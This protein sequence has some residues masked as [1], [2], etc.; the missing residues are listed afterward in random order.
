MISVLFVDDDPA[1]L[2]AGKQF[3]EQQGEF[4]VDTVESAMPALDGLSLKPYDAIISEYGM[5]VID[6]IEFLKKVRSQ[7]ITTPFIIFTG[8]GREEVAIEALNS[9]ADFYLR[10]GADPAS[11]FTTLS[12][13]IHQAITRKKAEDNLAGCGERYLP[14]AESANDMIFVTGADEVIRYANSFCAKMLNSHPENI[15]GKTLEEIFPEETAARLREGVRNQVLNG[16][17]ENFEVH[18]VTPAGGIWISIDNSPL[19][20]KNGTINAVL[21]IAQDITIKKQLEETLRLANR[22]LKA[23]SSATRH[24]INNKLTIISGY[25]QLMKL[26]EPHPG[27]QNIFQSWK[28]P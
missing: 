18:L 1:I 20:D 10:K 6:G 2:R 23:I 4:T 8:K 3:L 22:N 26:E 16:T 5:P 12:A 14:L 9:G 15:Q 13:V 25:I 28:G 11:Q 21:G 7:G 27:L 19:R 17:P 24:D